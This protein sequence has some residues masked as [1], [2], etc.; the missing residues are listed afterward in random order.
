MNTKGSTRCCID[1]VDADILD[2]DVCS[3][4]IIILIQRISSFAQYKQITPR[5]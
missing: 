1:R 4:V 2:V 5:I 3:I